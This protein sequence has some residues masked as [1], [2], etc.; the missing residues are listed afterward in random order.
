[1]S[2]FISYKIEEKGKKWVIRRPDNSIVNDWEFYTLEKANK[3]LD[4]LR[5]FNLDR[6]KRK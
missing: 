1:M 6:M 2:D 4:V 3:Y 5:H